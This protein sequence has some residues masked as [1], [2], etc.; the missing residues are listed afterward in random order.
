MTSPD[1]ASRPPWRTA[2]ILGVLAMAGKG[3]PVDV[4]AREL[5]NK[6]RQLLPIGY[7]CCAVLLELS[8][9]RRSIHVWNGGLPPVLIKRRSQPGYEKIASHSLPLGVVGND[10][11][12]STAQRH[13][14]HAGDLL[15]AYSDG[16]TEAENFD[17]EMWGST[18]WRHFCS[19]QTC[20]RHDCR[21]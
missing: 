18:G 3:L 15:Y 1:T 19:A 13:H 4:I 9:D 14:L 21:H 11:F 2:G 10:E 6:L 12:E 17:G 7:F 20:P 5:N 16:L 8:A